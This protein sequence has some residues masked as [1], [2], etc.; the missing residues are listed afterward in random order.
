M[1]SSPDRLLE[2]LRQH[3]PVPNA[4]VRRSIALRWFAT[5]CVGS[6][7][8]WGLY[9]G[10]TGTQRFAPL[11]GWTALAVSI[12]GLLAIASGWMARRRHGCDAQWGFARLGEK[13]VREL[14]AIANADPAL[15]EI[16]DLWASRWVE[17]RSNLRGRDLML[18]RRKAR[19]YLKAR[20]A[21]LPSLS[22]R[23]SR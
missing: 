20:G 4:V 18:L 3:Q 10:L 14:S 16:V 19:A 6:L 12:A 21:T 9:V 1:V 17:T 13:E 7:A 8:P 2:T 5:L 23:V 15:G 11:S 22:P